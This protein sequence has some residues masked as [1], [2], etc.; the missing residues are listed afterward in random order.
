MCRH[1]EFIFV[2]KLVFHDFDQFQ[3][4]SLL[5]PKTSNARV[6]HKLK[7][8]IRHIEM[9]SFSIVLTSLKTIEI[10]PQFF[11]GRGES[12]VIKYNIYSSA[13]VLTQCFRQIHI[14]TKAF[15]THYRI[16]LLKVPF[17]YNRGNYCY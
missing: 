9:L 4:D 3:S 14:N 1:M 5:I 11:V 17:S 13:W 10:L 12:F 15:Y 2:Q 8:T 16:T 7:N 6:P